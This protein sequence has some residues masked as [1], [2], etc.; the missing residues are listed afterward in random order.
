MEVRIGKCASCRAAGHYDA[1]RRRLVREDRPDLGPD[2]KV[3]SCGHCNRLH[4][5]QD[6]GS[7]S[8]TV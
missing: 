4:V 5:L 2:G 7:F 1:D 8:P 3:F 6:D